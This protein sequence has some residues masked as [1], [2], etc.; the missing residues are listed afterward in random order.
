MVKTCEWTELPLP[1]AKGTY[2]CRTQCHCRVYS[3]PAPGGKKTTQ[4]WP[5]HPRPT[6]DQWLA[7][8]PARA[9]QCKECPNARMVPSATKVQT[10]PYQS[11]GEH[12]KWEDPRATNSPS[13]IL[14][15]RRSSA[16][17]LL[18]ATRVQTAPQK[19]KNTHFSSQTFALTSASSLTSTPVMKSKEREMELVTGSVDTG[20]ASQW[21]RE[22]FMSGVKQITKEGNL[23]KETRFTAN[24]C[25]LKPL[26]AALPK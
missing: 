17:K 26:I 3:T 24:C 4:G 23:R 20:G 16:R 14:E 22:D 12:Q 13:P 5:D 25:Q 21:P 7:A 10:A 8:P 11:D 9:P 1:P 15:L 19:E 2:V 18:Y 6:K